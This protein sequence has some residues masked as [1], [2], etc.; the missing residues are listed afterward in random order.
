MP[1]SSG[2]H[3][4]GDSVSLHIGGAQGY[5]IIIFIIGTNTCYQPTIGTLLVVVQI[6]T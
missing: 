3:T 1:V 4:C 6:L 2:V 5:C